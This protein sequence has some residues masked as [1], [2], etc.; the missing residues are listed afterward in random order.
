[1]KSLYKISDSA[2]FVSEMT[3]CVAV[4]FV[5]LPLIFVSAFVFVFIKRNRKVKNE[6]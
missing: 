5:L 4:N 3:R 2:E 6:K 1:M